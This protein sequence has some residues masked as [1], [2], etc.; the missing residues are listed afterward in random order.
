MIKQFK[1]KF[2]VAFQ[3]LFQGIKTDPSIQLQSALAA[4]TL[5]FFLILKINWVEWL[6]VLSAV[7][8]VLITEFL[9]SALEDFSDLIECKYN[10]KVKSIKDT[11][12]AAVLLAAFY[13]VSVA[14]IIILRRWL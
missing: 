14:V 12:A 13:A 2:A 7:F 6:F 5:L 10:L 4:V 3:G 9:N 8:L 1:N 11:A